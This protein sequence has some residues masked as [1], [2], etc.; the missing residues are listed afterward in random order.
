MTTVYTLTEYDAQLLLEK[1]SWRP[2]AIIDPER[3]AK[4]KADI[5]ALKLSCVDVWPG[6]EMKYCWA[7]PKFDN[8]D[9]PTPAEE[10][11]TLAAGSSER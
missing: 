5:L 11:S 7:G 10:R 1:V 9:L 4:R 2:L 6:G 3:E 8:D